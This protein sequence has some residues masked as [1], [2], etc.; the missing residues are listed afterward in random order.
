MSG[1]GSARAVRNARWNVRL[2]VFEKRVLHPFFSLAWL[3]AAHKV[4]ALSLGERLKL[5]LIYIASSKN[6]T[7]RTAYGRLPFATVVFCSI[8][9]SKNFDAFAWRF[10]VRPRT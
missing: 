2:E 1:N 9:I 6:A 8:W 10:P 4:R 7:K 5:A 3:P